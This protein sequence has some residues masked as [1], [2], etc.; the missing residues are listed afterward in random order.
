MKAPKPRRFH[1]NIRRYHPYSS[2]LSHA[3]AS[4]TR[5]SIEGLEDGQASYNDITERQAAQ[6]AHTRHQDI[7]GQAIIKDGDGDIL[8]REITPQ[9][10]GDD[11]ICVKCASLDL[12]SA[13]QKAAQI[14]ESKA[15]HKNEL[16]HGI[17]IADVGHHYREL[18]Q[19]DCVLCSVLFTSRIGLGQDRTAEDDS[20]GD[21]IRLIGFLQCADFVLY[22]TN[23]WYQDSAHL[24][25][26]PRPFLPDSI[27]RN[28]RIPLLDQV[29]NTGASVLLPDGNEPAMFAAQAVPA[30]FNVETAQGWLHYCKRNHSLLCGGLNGSSVSGLRLIEC[31][32]LTIGEA[33]SNMS[34]VA[35]S[36]VWGGTGQFDTKLRCT[37]YNRHLL[38]AKLSPIISDAIRVT[39]ALG[40]QY[41]WVDKFCIDQDNPVTKHEQ[42]KRMSAIYENADLTIVAAAGVD[43]TYG[44]PGAGERPRTPQKTARFNGM[45]VIATMK[46]PQVSIRSSHWA[47][48]GW[49]FQEA[50]LSRRRLFFTD[51]QL[52][53]ECNSM[54]CF[55]SIS[56]PL[57]MLHTKD[58]SRSLDS[59]RGG[60]F[61]RSSTEKFGNL[62]PGETIFHDVFDRYLSAVKDYSSRDLR[63]DSDS[64]NAFEGIIQRY[65]KL[66]VPVSAIWGMPYHPRRIPDH[67]GQR[68]FYFCCSLTWSHKHSCWDGS[69]R[70]RRRQALPSWTWAGWAGAVQINE[71][72]GGKESTVEFLL[73]DYITAVQFGD[74]GSINMDSVPLCRISPESKYRVLRVL[75]QGVPP[76]VFSCNPT[77]DGK[78]GWKLTE[79][80]AKLFPSQDRM[81]KAQFVQELMD[82]MKWRCIWVCSMRR[83]SFIMVLELNRD[84]STWERAGMF[85]V[86][87]SQS[88]TLPIRRG[89]RET[90]V[91]IE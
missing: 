77:K 86:D 9:L 22:P 43:E 23:F 20:D 10:L 63:Y 73:A 51:Q 70:P 17:H 52:Y 12:R 45:R 14:R 29:H 48:R 56:S 60:M 81:F 21:E 44:L 57:D 85:Y 36:Y 66:H 65:S 31:S 42:I 3:R 59:L 83:K 41:L 15:V 68:S 79:H 50:V 6:T 37:R 2:F 53:F 30:L 69:R 5:T 28:Y 32:T 13:L 35:L 58:K 80:D 90:W 61:G 71:L 26:V 25:V 40:F 49:T 27:D 89:I 82:V 67:D 24:I 38:P 39:R 88:D 75:A 76:N 47:S 19:T 62:V 11:S 46:D 78:M 55:E 74:R 84:T 1:Q 87:C 72:K 34:Y 8:M 18:G 91:D 54:N 7:C 33:K 64:L 16:W 4:R